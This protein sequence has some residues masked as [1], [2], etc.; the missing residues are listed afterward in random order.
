MM[1]TGFGGRYD[2][3]IVARLELTEVDRMKRTVFAWLL[4]FALTTPA[5]AADAKAPPAT[6]RQKAA[7][8]TDAKVFKGDFEAMKKRRTIRVA[9]PYSR[10]LFFNDGGV[11]RGITA[12]TIQEFERWLNKK[13]KTGKHPP[14]EQGIMKTVSWVMSDGKHLA[15]AQ[16]ATRAA[17][18]VFGKRWLGKL[19][20]PIASRW[21]R[22]RDVEAPPTQTFRQWWKKNREGE[23]R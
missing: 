21:L 5:I 8:S 3:A 22:A 6:S 16:L 13:Y 12:D 7:L 9:V 18:G 23:G 4:L 17:G 19:P 15:E 20:I 1:A 2:L 10:T 11:Q 14:V